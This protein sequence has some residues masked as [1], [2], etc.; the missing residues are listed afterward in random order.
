MAN[1]LAG[2]LKKI[3][4]NW[5][6]KD[7]IDDGDDRFSIND[8]NQEFIKSYG[9][10]DICLTEMYD[11]ENK[12]Y[13]SSS[14][15]GKVF[16]IKVKSETKKIDVLSNLVLICDIPNGYC[17][18]LLEK[19]TSDEHKFYMIVCSE[20]GYEDVNKINELNS[21]VADIESNL[22]DS[23]EVENLNPTDLI[24]L[25]KGIVYGYP[26]IESSEKNYLDDVL[27]RTQICEPEEKEVLI[28]CN[29][30]NINYMVGGDEY[31]GTFLG[32]KQYPVLEKDEDITK[33]DCNYVFDNLAERNKII[34]NNQCVMFSVCIYN[35]VK[36][37]YTKKDKSKIMVDERNKK[38][39]FCIGYLLTKSD[40][41]EHLESIEKFKKNMRDTDL[42]MDVIKN[43][44]LGAMSLLIP[45]NL[46]V[47]API[48]A[49]AM[50]LSK[51]VD[52]IE[53]KDLVSFVSFLD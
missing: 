22:E 6:L 46:T 40:E 10:S 37:K 21:V 36:K 4:E 19:K 12:V 43:R 11:D 20:G 9:I 44:Q 24:C 34:D 42:F 49:D 25:I 14:M 26:S 28:G 17:M 32:V 48:D 15:L 13:F 53:K 45:M 7:N 16:E 47:S 39:F 3:I 33:D 41:Q 35:P 27:I 29:K 8:I 23:F 2:K 30:N 31:I 5:L 18:Q 52:V 51:R 1:K 50:R 38:C